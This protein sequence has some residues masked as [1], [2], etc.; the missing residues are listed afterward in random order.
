MSGNAVPA[1]TTNFDCCGADSDTNGVEARFNDASAVRGAEVAS[2][3]ARGSSCAELPVDI[4][5]SS[6]FGS[7]SR[8][9]WIM[10]S[11]WPADCISGPGISHT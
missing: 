9:V 7:S 2:E 6:A 11:G 5:S 1:T 10:L 3:D 4:G 8:T